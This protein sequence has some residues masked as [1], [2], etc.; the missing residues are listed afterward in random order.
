V[1]F[2]GLDVCTIWP[3]GCNNFSVMKL[4]ARKGAKFE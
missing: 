1:T 4:D 2:A 3:D